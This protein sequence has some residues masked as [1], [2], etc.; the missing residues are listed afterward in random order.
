MKPYSC[1]AG[2]TG[3]KTL[4][5]PSSLA[6]G[7]EKTGPHESGG[8]GILIVFSL[9]YFTALSRKWIHQGKYVTIW[10]G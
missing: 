1:S 7:T 3:P 10:G 6:E 4:R 8:G 9:F 5:K 2:G